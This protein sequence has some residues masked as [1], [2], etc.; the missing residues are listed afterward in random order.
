MSGLRYFKGAADSRSHAVRL[1]HSERIPERI[2]AICG[3]P[4][5]P[6]REVGL[7]KAPTQV[8]AKCHKGRHALAARERT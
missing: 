1:A 2:T 6:G 8:C 5:D 4:C 7:T 3:A